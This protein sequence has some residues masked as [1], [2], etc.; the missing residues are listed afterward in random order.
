MLRF[1]TMD[2][3]DFHTSSTGMPA[4]GLDGSSWALGFTMSF[5]PMDR[6][7]FVV[8]ALI[9]AATPAQGAN[10][11]EATPRKDELRIPR[12]KGIQA[13]RP[14]MDERR[15]DGENASTGASAPERRGGTD[16]GFEA[17]KE[18]EAWQKERRTAPLKAR[19]E[20]RLQD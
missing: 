20:G 17:E 1:I 5:A 2:V 6:I 19:P 12:D 18:E 10:G 7:L 15:R 13:P 4:M 9:L 8:C 11:V 14:R 3:F 16:L